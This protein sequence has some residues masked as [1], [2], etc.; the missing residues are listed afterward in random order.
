MSAVTLN[1]IESGNPLSLAV[2]ATGGQEIGDLSV[3]GPTHRERL[4]ERRTAEKTGRVGLLLVTRRR[5]TVVTARAGQA[6]SAMRALP[7][8]GND[9]GI[10]P[11]VAG[12]ALIRL[13]P[14]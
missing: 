7:M 6:H 4:S 1:T 8:G 12:F 13:R 10:S 11:G 5:I 2:M 9:N 3:T 14:G